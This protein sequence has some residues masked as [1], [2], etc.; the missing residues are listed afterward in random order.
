MQGTSDGPRKGGAREGIWASAARPNPCPFPEGKGQGVCSGP[1]DTIIQLIHQ[2][3]GR[4]YRTRRDWQLRASHGP[5]RVIWCQC[6]AR[7]APLRAAAYFTS[8]TKCNASI[9]PPHGKGIMS[10]AAWKVE[11]SLRTACILN[12]TGV[13]FW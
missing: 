11:P 10:T 6:S 8:R 12:E 3:N 1:G 4:S 2:C 7:T 13:K 9:S 5:C